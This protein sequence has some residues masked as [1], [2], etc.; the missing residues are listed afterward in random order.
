[1]SRPGTRDAGF[2]LIELLIAITILGLIMGTLTNGALLVLRIRQPTEDRLATS[3]DVQSTDSYFAAD[4][5]NSGSQLYVR[6]SDTGYLLRRPLL[7]TKPPC[8]PA[9]LTVD[10]VVVTFTW[11]DV[12]YDPANPVAYDPANA[13]SN[14]NVRDR[15]AWYYVAR[16]KLPGG[17]PDLTRLATL[18]RGFCSSTQGVVTRSD[19]VVARNVSPTSAALFCDGVAETAAAS[20][21][22][23]DQPKVVAIKATLRLDSTQPFFV[24]AT[25]RVN[26]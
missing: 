8:A 1:M 3:H 13:S 22:G 18:R 12:T 6:Q 20:C 2:T 10:T 16:P 23:I 24:Q 15:W 21:T 11:R 25:R 4:V 19:T 14:P 7:T 5:Q 26:T 9:T 17:A